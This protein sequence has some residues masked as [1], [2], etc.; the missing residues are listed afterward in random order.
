MT[1]ETPRRVPAPDSDPRPWGTA[2]SGDVDPA[3][4]EAPGVVA[5]VQDP[6]AGRTPAEGV[7]TLA[8][9]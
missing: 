4:A 5:S 1:L 6:S 2:S 3:P 7:G 9:S 8:P